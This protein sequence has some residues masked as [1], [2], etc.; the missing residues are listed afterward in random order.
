MHITEFVQESIKKKRPTKSFRIETRDDEPCLIS[1][2]AS[3][4][5][6]GLTIDIWGAANMRLLNHL[7]ITGRLDRKD[8]EYY[9]AY[10]AHTFDLGRA[11]HV[12]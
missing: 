4:S 8:I 7:L 10:T 3:V 1:D 12:E 6:D 9:L 5:Y 11:I 2:E